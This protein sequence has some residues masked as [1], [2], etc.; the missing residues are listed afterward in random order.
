MAYDPKRTLAKG[1]TPAGVIIAGGKL[2][3][4]LA[5]K[6]GLTMDGETSFTI[7]TGVYATFRMLFNWLKNRKRSGL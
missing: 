2:L 7:V 5:N 6:A 1:A 4:W 3:E